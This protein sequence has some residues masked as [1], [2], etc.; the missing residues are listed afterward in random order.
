M[1]DQANGQAPATWD[2]QIGE[3]RDIGLSYMKSAVNAAAGTGGGLTAR[4]NSIHASGSCPFA[5]KRSTA[6]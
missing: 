6:T 4:Q 5:F 1:A 3:L 2:D